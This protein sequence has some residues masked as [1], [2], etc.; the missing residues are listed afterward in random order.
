MQG[1]PDDKSASEGGALRRGPSGFGSVFP[2]EIGVTHLGHYQLSG[3]SSQAARIRRRNGRMI[4]VPSSEAP[5][6]AVVLQP[7]QY[8]GATDPY[9]GDIDE[10]LGGKLAGSTFCGAD[11]GF[12][13]PTR[14]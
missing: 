5:E 3:A 1:R 11:F 8:G 13:V 9:P 4:T 7:D 10:R 12:H 2:G 14:P 6:M